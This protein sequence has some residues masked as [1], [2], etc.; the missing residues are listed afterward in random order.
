MKDELEFLTKATSFTQEELRHWHKDFLTVS[1][2]RAG[3]FRYFL[4]LSIIKYDF[5]D[6]FVKLIWLGVGF[7]KGLVQK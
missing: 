1:R 3:H 4:V 6:F 7:L 5:L 2:R